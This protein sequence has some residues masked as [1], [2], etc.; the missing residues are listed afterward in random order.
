MSEYVLSYNGSNIVLRYSPNIAFK[1]SNI[2]FQLSIIVLQMSNIVLQLSV[3][4]LQ[5]PHSCLILV[6][7][8]NN[9]NIALQ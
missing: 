7:P 2:V 6:L 9:P 8:C 3:I 4:V 1:L 5:L